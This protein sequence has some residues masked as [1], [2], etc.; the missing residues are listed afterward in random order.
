VGPRAEGPLTGIGVAVTRDDGDDA[1]LATLLRNHG[2]TVVSWPAIRWVPPDHVAPLDA[3]LNRLGDFH[4][5]VLTSPR[6]VEAVAARRPAWPP[7][8]RI[9]VVGGATRAAAESR[10]W[11][12]HLV[13][14]T[15]TAE[16]L[17][18]A[19]AGAGAGS[20]TRVFFPASEIASATLE[21]GL[22]SL[23]A[24]VVRVTAYR[25][26]PAELDREACARSLAAGAVQVISIASPS[27]VEG[28]RAALGDRLFNDAIAHA[29]VAAIGPTT[30]AAARAA[31]AKRVIEASDHSLAGLADR[32]AAWA[33]STREEH[34]ELSDE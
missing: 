19:L 14:S 28:L 6:A 22:R 13:P 30:A 17:V 34:H 15:Q 3:A 25:T 29:V 11:P 10:G 26:L 33:A 18:A 4:W 5:A 12:V 21:M 23:G 2:A 24:E 9:A 32:I 8:V 20:G 7:T 31:G 16:A 27:A 1:A